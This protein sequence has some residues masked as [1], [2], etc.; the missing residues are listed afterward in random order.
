MDLAVDGQ[1]RGQAAGAQAGHGLQ[2]EQAVGIG[3]ALA[4]EVHIV[5]DGVI[6][7]LGLADMAGGTVTHPDDVLALGLQ[8]KI[9]IKCRY[10]VD[11]GRADA[12]AVGDEG[13]VLLAEVVEG[14]LRILQYGDQLAGL[15]AVGVDNLA[16]PGKS[17]V[18]A[19]VFSP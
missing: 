17:L 16:H 6:N 13:H 1:H 8:G 18:H 15:G 19:H 10:A 4:G 3:L 9:L 11:L 2:G 5:V 12:Q 7:G 14:R